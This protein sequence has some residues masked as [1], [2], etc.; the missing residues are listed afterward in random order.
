MIVSLAE[1]T[2]M[3]VVIVSKGRPECL[4]P[5]IFT[6]AKVCVPESQMADYAAQFGEDRVVGIPEQDC[7]NAAKARNFC[8][9]TLG[10]ALFV[11]DMTAGMGEWYGP[12][13]FGPI[14]AADFLDHVGQVAEICSD[15]GYLLAG[16]QV[17]SSTFSP[18][19]F[20][21]FTFGSGIRY[22][23][24]LVVYAAK[25]FPGFDE[26]YDHYEVLKSFLDEK[27]VV[28]NYLNV[29]SKA[30]RS[31]GKWRLSGRDQEAERLAAQS[32]SVVRRG[33]AVYI[34]SRGKGNERKR[35]NRNAR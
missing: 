19:S 15:V 20:E 16:W 29:L 22:P 1:M 13:E 7:K 30:S 28:V 2:A 4:A 25:G 17:A 34:D 35:S 12:G 21:P 24:N 26:S 9:D 8:I 5:R 23:G 33:R 31:G 32:K 6:T 10:S 14:A 27:S 3:N 18:M 11:D